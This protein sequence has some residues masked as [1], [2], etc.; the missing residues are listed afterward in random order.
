MSVENEKVCYNCRHC[1]RERNEE[2]LYTYCY[3]EIDKRHLCY[4]EVMGLWCR[5]WAKKKGDEE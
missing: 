4:V 1:I 5:R 3:C 2:T